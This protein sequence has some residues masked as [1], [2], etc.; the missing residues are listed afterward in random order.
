MSKILRM[1]SLP[2]IILN[3]FTTPAIRMTKSPYPE[4]WNKSESL[5]TQ[6]HVGYCHE[7]N[8]EYFH[9]KVKGEPHSI[10][11]KKF[12]MKKAENAGFFDMIFLFENSVTFYLELKKGGTGGIWAGHQID[13]YNKVI[14]RGGFALCS[15]SLKITHQYLLSKGLVK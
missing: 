8:I 9:T 1:K 12:I 4:D 7:R 13:Q 10:G 6:E 3:Q 2:K 14:K 5:I 15:N 11:P